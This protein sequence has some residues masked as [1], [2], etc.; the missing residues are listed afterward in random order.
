MRIITC[1]SPSTTETTV[2]RGLVNDERRVVIS[3][4]WGEPLRTTYAKVRDR[5][6]D[7]EAAQIAR[8]FGLE[9]P[10]GAS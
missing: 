1:Y 5:L 6:T 9:P 8:A 2:M 10:G 3:T 7:E 4:R